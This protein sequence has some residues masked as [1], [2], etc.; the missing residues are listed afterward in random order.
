MD[1]K[2]AAHIIRAPSNNEDSSQIGSNN[3]GDNT[4][5][6][7][8]SAEISNPD[9]PKSSQREKPSLSPY[10]SASW[11]SNALFHWPVHI[12]RLCLAKDRFNPNSVPTLNRELESSRNSAAFVKAFADQELTIFNLWKCILKIY[13]KD[14]LFL[15]G[16]HLM[17]IIGNITSTLT[18]RQI[19]D[20]LGSKSPKADYSAILIGIAFSFLGLVIKAFAN[21]HL[22]YRAT[23]TGAKVRVGLTAF[24]YSRLLNMKLSCGVSS[25]KVV[26]FVSNDL[27]RYENVFP[28]LHYTYMPWIEF[29]VTIYFLYDKLDS[30]TPAIIGGIVILI[31]FAFQMVVSFQMVAVQEKLSQK[32]DEVVKIISD[33]F[34]GILPIKCFNWQH[35]FQDEINTSRDKL[36]PLIRRMNVLEGVNTSLHFVAPNLS[37]FFLC[38]VQI[39]FLR[40]SLDEAKIIMINAYFTLSSFSMS[41]L[42]PIAIAGVGQINSAH[43]RFIKICDA[44]EVGEDKQIEYSIGNEE[45]SCIR[46]EN[47]SISWNRISQPN[48]DEGIEESESPSEI[49]KSANMKSFVLD[50]SHLEIQKGEFVAL[51]GSVGGKNDI[52]AFSFG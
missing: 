33:T 5:A 15:F 48:S 45:N 1:R 17:E 52:L 12:I 32:R 19:I 23:M 31:L 25:A 8:L 34:S 22:T 49:P 26:N 46:F 39:V 6:G 50:I 18:M 29:L 37:V 40:K 47:V 30:L 2:K 3:R 16:A 43:E 9:H 7:A 24:L 36:E 10:D 11:I 35:I 21:Q 38:L 44:I 27:Q 42:L 20:E 41:Y 13:W 51:V 28:L 14:N 4:T